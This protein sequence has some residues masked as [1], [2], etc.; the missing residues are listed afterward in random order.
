[1]KHLIAFIGSRSGGLQKV[2]ST[3]ATI[4]NAQD[5]SSSQIYTPTYKLEEGEWFSIT[6]FKDKGFDNDFIDKSSPLTTTSLNQLVE[7]DYHKIK[8]LSFEDTGIKYFQKMLSSN[9]ISKKWFCISS[10]PELEENRKII[11]MNN[12]PDAIYVI[13]SDTLYF[14][15]IS[16]IKNIFKGIDSLY[17]EATQVEV[18][19]FLNQNFIELKNGFSGANVKVPNRKR[20][21]LV[22]DKLEQF[23]ETEKN[24]IFNYIH[25][26]CTDVTYENGKF[27]ITTE[28][29]LKLVLFGIDERYYT[30]NLGQEKRLANS[31]TTMS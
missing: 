29:D 20:L 1:M 15:D 10:A 7:G 18:D 13:A 2:L 9:T 23:N 27:A 11:T 28:N 12:K 3:N 6:E 14:K 16:R 26:Y 4:F 5:T 25:T 19:D 8:Y 17:R 21:A 22:V 30:T 24:T 31:V